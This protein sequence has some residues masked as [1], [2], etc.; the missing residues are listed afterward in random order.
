MTEQETVPTRPSSGAA[1]ELLRRAAERTMRFDFT[2]WFW[3]DPIALDGLLEASALLRDQ[4]FAD[5]AASFAR[6]WCARGV[7]DWNDANAPGRAFNDLYRRTGDPVYLEGSLRLADH[8]MH[9]VPRSYDP[10]CPIYTPDRVTHR[11]YAWVDSIYHVPPYFADLAELTGDDAY[12]RH[13][14][15]VLDA[16]VDCL[17]DEATGLFPQGR[18]LSSDVIKGLGWGRGMAWAYVGIVDTLD[19]LEDGPERERLVDLFRRL[20]DVLLPLQTDSGAWRNLVQDEQAPIE[21]STAALIG[22][23]LEKGCRLGILGPEAR[24]GAERAWD[25]VLENID[26]QGGLPNVSACSW[27]ANNPGDDRDVYRS[28]GVEVN[29]WGQGSLLRAC[30]ERILASG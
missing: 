21:G 24:T 9:R 15:Y 5:R 22:A 3:G 1:S 20:T 4:R 27:V 6:P 14:L 11:T 12:R 7:V 19:L 30:T 23:G 25:H 8:L 18:D 2:E 10:E 17:L 13:A 26:G 16:H 29:V 28:F